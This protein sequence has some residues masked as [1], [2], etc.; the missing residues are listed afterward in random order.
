MVQLIRRDIVPQIIS[1]IV[2]EPKL[3]G[4]R[5][6]VEADRITNTPSKYL[7]PGSVGF[8]TADKGVTIFVGLA[9]IA[10]R[11]HWD[12]QQPVGDQKP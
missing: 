6:P 2:G 3:L 11:P 1:P 9:Y 7:T 10:R 4:Y 8:Q 12:I 5:M